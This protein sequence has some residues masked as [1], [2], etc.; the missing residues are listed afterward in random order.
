MK[1]V[2]ALV[3]SSGIFTNPPTKTQKHSNPYQYSRARSLGTS[4]KKSIVTTTS[5]CGRWLFKHWMEKGKQ[6]Y[7]LVDDNLEIIELS[8]TKGGPWLQSFGHSNLL[9]ARATRA[10]TNHTPIGEYHL[11]FFPKEDFKYLYEYYPIETRRHILY[12][13]TRY[14][15]YWNPRRNTLSHFVMF[16]SANPE[17]FAFT[18]NVSSVIPSWSRND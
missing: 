6:F 9:C 7:D 15:G 18:D 10:I 11:W 3:D 16:L 17:A 4:V 5:T 14:N 13:C 12:E 1:F 8:Y 2:T